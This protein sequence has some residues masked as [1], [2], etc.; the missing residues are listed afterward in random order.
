MLGVIMVIRIQMGV[1]MMT[2][3][4]HDDVCDNDDNGY[5]NDDLR[6][7]NDDNRYNNDDLRCDDND[8]NGNYIDI[9][10]NDQ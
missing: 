3:C 7:N 8:E 6:Y 10:A 9:H 1:I 5:D 4:D 2:I